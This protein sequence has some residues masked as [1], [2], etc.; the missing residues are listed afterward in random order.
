MTYCVIP[1][2]LARKLGGALRRRYA[3]DSA[4]KVI[5]DR[6]FGDRRG[7]GDRRS[8]TIATM[9]PALDRR[10]A[11]NPD[12]RRVA[13]RRAMVVP[14]EPQPL[15]RRAQRYADRIRWVTR[16]EPSIQ[17]VEDV[18]AARLIC[19]AQTG[20][21]GALQALY[22]SSFDRVYTFLRLTLGD[23]DVAEELTNEVFG[24]VVE[25]LAGYEI[26]SEPFRVWI[27][28]V[29]LARAAAHTV[30]QRVNGAA[31]EA[32]PVDPELRNAAD[33]EDLAP[34]DALTDAELVLL[35]ESLPTTQRQVLLL[36]Y[37]MGLSIGEVAAVSGM[38]PDAVRQYHTRALEVL[39]G[40][41][42]FLSRPSRS[43]SRNSMTRLRRLGPVLRE[44]KYAMT[45]W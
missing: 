34:L 24:E 33:S 38:S 3:D 39:D 29:M 9:P 7:G 30:G 43:A 31:L 22:L 11:R 6:R 37:Q 10:L 15:P 14:A 27:A 18:E 19:L 13:P 4:V 17:H 40:K 16:L 28:R 2:E 26:S 12:G 20:D 36:R 23:N 41:L 35:I 21:R 25:D 1:A 42:S 5:V 32:D 44:R 8:Q 45:A